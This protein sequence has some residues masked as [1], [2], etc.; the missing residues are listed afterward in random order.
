MITLIVG[1]NRPGSNSRKVAAHV[2]EIHAFRPCA[3]FAA[4][5]LIEPTG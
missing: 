3:T 5:L 4:N 2:E 1:T